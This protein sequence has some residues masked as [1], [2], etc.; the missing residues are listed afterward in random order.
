MKEIFE[1]ILKDNKGFKNNIFFR[2][3][4]YTEKNV[5]NMDNLEKKKF[6]H[7]FNEAHVDDILTHFETTNEILN[8]YQKKAKIIIDDED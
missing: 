7:T 6:S 8:K 2:N 5:G 1:K 4:N 3:I